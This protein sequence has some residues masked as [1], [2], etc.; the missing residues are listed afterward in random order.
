MKSN[1][2]KI[3]N[4]FK[5]SLRGMIKA[6]H[7]LNVVKYWIIRAPYSMDGHSEK[8]SQTILESFQDHRSLV[9]IYNTKQRMV[10]YGLNLKHLISIELS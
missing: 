1:G 3:L 4:D 5:L 8:L 9:S 7:F 6:R 2:E 10:A